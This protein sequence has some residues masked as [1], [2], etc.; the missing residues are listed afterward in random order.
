MLAG[1]SQAR[2]R[3]GVAPGTPNSS[4]AGQKISKALT[5]P[6]R[7]IPA[8]N[9]AGVLAAK[10]AMR[11]RP[12]T[13]KSAISE[14]GCVLRPDDEHPG[15]MPLDSGQ[16]G[17]PVANVLVPCHGYP[18]PSPDQRYPSLVRRIARKVVVMDLHPHPRGA[19]AIRND[20]SSEI[21]IEKKGGFVRRQSGARTGSLLRSPHPRVRSRAPDRKP[22]RRPCSARRSPGWRARCPR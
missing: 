15:R 13:S 12:A 17:C 21:A 5:C 19:Q 20:V 3:R 22:T 4:A 10:P 7:Y 16:F 9:G 6:P 11:R 18:A 2:E 14:A 1:T 8:T